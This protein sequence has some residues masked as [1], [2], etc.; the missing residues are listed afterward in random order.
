MVSKACLMSLVFLMAISTAVSAQEQISTDA[1]PEKATAGTPSI[2]SIIPS[3][4]QLFGDT[5]YEIKALAEIPSDP[6]KLSEIRSELE[7]PLATTMVGLTLDWESSAGLWGLQAGAAVNLS[8]PSDPMIDRDWMGGVPVSYTE[9]DAE[10]NM[11]LA[12]IEARYGILGKPKTKLWLLARFEFQKISQ[13]I[14]GFAGWQDLDMDGNRVQVSGTELVIDYEIT[15]LTPQLGVGSRFILGKATPLNVNFAAGVLF[16]SDTDDHLLR[17]RIS[18][19]EATGLSLNTNT[20][21][22]VLST[23][24][25]GGVLF[26]DLMGWLRYYYATGD[27]TQTWYRDEESNPAGTVV[28]GIA[29]EVDSLQYGFGLRLGLGF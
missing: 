20:D 27:Q 14:I 13:D 23:E 10:M 8:D 1:P 7:F 11:V 22:R 12:H 6:G 9:S 29:Y 25:L 5:T 2:F 16:S 17:G 21:L 19:G 26:L 18:E 4:Y 3:V 15:Y 28:S 24:A